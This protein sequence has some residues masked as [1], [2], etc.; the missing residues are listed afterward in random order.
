MNSALAG[1]SPAAHG[2]G[3][4]TGAQLCTNMSA[5]SAFARFRES[6]S[7]SRS[8]PELQQLTKIHYHYRLAGRLSKLDRESYRESHAAMPK[9]GMPIGLTFTLVT[10][11]LDPAVVHWYIDNIAPNSGVV[12]SGSAG[13]GYNHASQLPNLSQF[14]GT[15]ASLASF[16]TSKISSLS[17]GPVQIP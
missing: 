8:T 12:T 4:Y 2:G 9:A 5:K 15:G 16:P 10:Q 17:R 1:S 3:Y 6:L 14:L 11:W 7:K 13:I